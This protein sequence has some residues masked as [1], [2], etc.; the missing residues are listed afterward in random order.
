MVDGVA[1]VYCEGMFQTIWGKTAHGLVRFTR[2]YDVFGVIDSSCSNQDALELLDGKKSGIYIYKDIDSALK[3]AKKEG[4]K[5]EYLVFGGATDG[6]FLPSEMYQDLL[7]ALKLGLNVDC[8][9]HFF[10]SEDPQMVEAANKSGAKIRDIRKTGAPHTLHGYTGKIRE[11]KS[12]KIAILGTDSSVGKRTTAWRLIDAF[13]K[14]GIKTELIGTGQTAWLQ[15]AR[16]G[17]RMDALVNDFVAGEIENSVIE[18]WNNEKPE[19]MIIEGQGSMLNPI[20]PGGFEIVA[21]SS[22]DVIVLQHAPNRVDYDGIVG[23][24]IHPLKVQIEAIELISSK[25]VVA[26]TLNKENLSIDELE[27]VKKEIEK[28]S[29]LITK[30]GLVDNLD[31]IVDILLAKK[32]ELKK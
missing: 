31:P 28:E 2:R 13:E 9:L 27:K 10:L 4:K 23:T 17:V 24:K 8:G 15:G 29:G 16:Y 21:A 18:A 26:I 1:L 20:Y 14:R 3:A 11:V 22:P 12:F 32:S 7:Y 30:E 19:V 25:K 5:V 6:G